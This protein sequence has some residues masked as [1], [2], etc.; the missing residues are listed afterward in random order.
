L[1]T[2]QGIILHGMPVSPIGGNL[3]GGA[4]VFLRSPLIH[5]SQS[6]S[7][8]EVRAS[9]S[10]HPANGSAARSFSSG[11]PLIRT[12]REELGDSTSNRETLH[13]LMNSSIESLHRTME[14]LHTKTLQMREHMAA[15]TEAIQKVKQQMPSFGAI[16]LHRQCV[17]QWNALRVF[18]EV[19]VGS[20]CSCNETLSVGKGIRTFAQAEM[21]TLSKIGSVVHFEW[22]RFKRALPLDDSYYDYVDF[23]CSFGPRKSKYVNMTCQEEE[24][25]WRQVMQFSLFHEVVGNIIRLKKSETKNLSWNTIVEYLETK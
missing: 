5:S 18:E 22:C 13:S 4:N 20:L 9:S 16:Q 12:L 8:N 25:G 15:S 17:K 7:M 6:V 2:I 23:L 1:K 19:V 10:F 24:T 14:T 21:A 11:L 3:E